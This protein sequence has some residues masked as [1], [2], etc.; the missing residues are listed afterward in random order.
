MFH[1]IPIP[2]TGKR[3][4]AHFTLPFLGQFLVIA[5]VIALLVLYVSG[6]FRLF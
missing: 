6:F 4:P 2:G 1:L 5:L 3:H